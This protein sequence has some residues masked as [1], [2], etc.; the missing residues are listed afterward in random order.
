MIYVRAPYHLDTNLYLSFSNDT[1]DNSQSMKQL[2]FISSASSLNSSLKKSGTLEEK[3]EKSRHY[4]ISS[5][6]KKNAVENCYFKQ[7]LLESVP[8]CEPKIYEVRRPMSVEHS[9]KETVSV[10]TGP[11]ELPFSRDS[12]AGTQKTIKKNVIF[13]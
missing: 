3:K 9:I 12:S 7:G 2:S 1:R 4:M 13:S 11:K 8:R 5:E 10:G 6:N